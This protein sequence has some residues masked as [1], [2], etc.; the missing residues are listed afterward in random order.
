MGRVTLSHLKEHRQNQTR[1]SMVTAYDACFSQVASS[2]GIDTL[3]VGD[4]LG[5][6]LQGHDSTLPVTVDD[7]AYHT[8]C[9]AGGAPH[10]FIVSDMPFMAAATPQD[11]VNATRALM[12]AGAHA[13]KVEGGANL[14]DL[15]KLLKDQGV[16]TCCHLGLT[17]QFVNQFGGYKVQ[18]RTAE[19]QKRLV[20][21]AHQ[22]DQQG[23]D[24]LL[25][26]CVPNRVTEQIMD[27]TNVP[28]I[29]I[30]AGP[31]CTGQVLVMHDLL[32]ITPGKPARFVKNFM[33]GSPSIQAAFKAYH[34]AVQ[35]GTFPA[36]EHC[37]VE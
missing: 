5:M 6:V 30:G 36:L 26:E 19:A 28:V 21:A 37:F 16:A 14:V 22:L 17:P 10:C 34:E 9:V 11:A 8:A 3:L 35:S 27:A 20:D 31:A 23:A 15:V 7:V 18:G 25:L 24:L 2:A 13:I 29:G 1:F 32:G 4:S 33:Q 12:Q